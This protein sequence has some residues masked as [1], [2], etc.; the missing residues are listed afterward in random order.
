M[1]LSLGC[2][3]PVKIECRVCRATKIK[4]QN[5]SQ[6]TKHLVGPAGE[7]LEE[8]RDAPRARVLEDVV[9][10][11]RLRLGDHDDVHQPDSRDAQLHTRNKHIVAHQKRPSYTATIGGEKRQQTFR[12]ADERAGEENNASERKK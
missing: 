7:A 6:Q 2:L 5:R 4:K 12:L 11:E 10:H 9:L 3:L 8:K 1:T